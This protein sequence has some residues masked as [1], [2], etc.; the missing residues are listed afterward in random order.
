MNNPAAIAFTSATHP[1]AF[2]SSA[3][4]AITRKIGSV[5][6]ARM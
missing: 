6:D 1:R 5:F 2:A 3:A 4:S